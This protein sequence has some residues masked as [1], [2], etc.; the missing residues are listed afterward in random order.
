M[1]SSVSSYCQILKTEETDPTKNRISTY[2]E[3]L[4]ASL[5]VINTILYVH[6]CGC[7]CV[8][9]SQRSMPTPA[10]W[11][12]IA[13]LFI[14]RALVITR[15]SNQY[16]KLEREGMG[17][18]RKETQ[19]PTPAPLAPWQPPPHY[20]MLQVR[21]GPRRDGR[22]AARARLRVGAREMAVTVWLMPLSSFLHTG[23]AKC[24]KLGQISSDGRNP[25]GCI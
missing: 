5:C 24:T 23:N 17:K 7:V 16:R 25:T 3:C 14:S 8:G 13:L 4:Q 2:S 15:P 18:Q 21:G 20:G 19:H 9:R 11:I 10:S 12:E 6:V 1:C 22:A